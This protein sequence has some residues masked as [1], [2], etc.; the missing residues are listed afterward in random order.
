VT[1]PEPSPFGGGELGPIPYLRPHTG[2][3]GFRRRGERLAELAP[4]HAAGDFLAFVGALAAAQAE[5]AGQLRLPPRAGLPAARP[6][7][8]G[9]PPPPEWREALALLARR[10]A[11]AA[12]PDAARQALAS[13]ERRGAAELDALAGRFLRGDLAAADVGP[14][15]FVGAGLQVAYACLAAG[16]PR[17]A[18]ARGEDA[19]CPVC[20]FPPV[21]GIVLPEDK[22]RY[23]VCGL[24]AST[25]HLTRVQ[26]AVCR[27]GEKVGYLALEGVDGPAKAETCES[28]HAYTKLLYLEKAL[29]LEP[30]ADDLAT[31]ALD[32]LVAERG[33]LRN[34]RSPYLVTAAE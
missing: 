25:W 5:V 31:L 28:C 1:A 12:M 34:G 17:E 22:V 8:V 19:G 33:Y 10:L 2:A 4:G 27:S 9:R 32:L 11:G 24:C 15:V 6:L 16:L 29:Q 23:L 26:C 30:F 13:L 18:V 20:G 21:V 14:A 3:A 7:D